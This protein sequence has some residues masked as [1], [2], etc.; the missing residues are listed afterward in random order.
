M[1]FT[2]AAVFF[3]L[4]VS[5]GGAAVYYQRKIANLQIL[6]NN[7]ME[8]LER[9]WYK[10]GWFDGDENARDNTRSKKFSV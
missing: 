3:T 7:E 9:D 4:V 5:L 6:W 1:L 8:K 10:A 2:V